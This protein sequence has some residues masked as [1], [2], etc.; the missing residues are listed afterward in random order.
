[1]GGIGAL[2][3]TF[4]GIA[5][6]FLILLIL[7]EVIRLIG[8][9]FGESVPQPQ[10]ISTGSSFADLDYFKK[11]E[12]RDVAIITTIMKKMGCTGSLKVKRIK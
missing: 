2:G 9:A 1:M 12:Q 7:S 11:R 3:I 8:V 4:I 5:A 10:T 6:V